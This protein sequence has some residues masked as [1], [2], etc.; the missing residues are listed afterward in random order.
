MTKK[1]STQFEMY[2][3]TRLFHILFLYCIKSNHCAVSTMQMHL[4][5]KMDVQ[6]DCLSA[7][8]STI[9][10]LSV[11][12]IF[13]SD[14]SCVCSPYLQ[15]EFSSHLLLYASGLTGFY[16]CLIFLSP[17]LF[18][19]FFDLYVCQCWFVVVVGIQLWATFLQ[20]S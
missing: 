16:P 20:V 6:T 1:R 13:N 12:S 17:S 10:A 3:F 11:S 8:I 15:K 14:P 2:L 5:Y 7:S 18:L 9:R 19:S 4:F